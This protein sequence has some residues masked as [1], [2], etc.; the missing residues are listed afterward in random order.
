MIR[1]IL[2]VVLS[3][4]W[5]LDHTANDNWRTAYELKQS[6]DTHVPFPPGTCPCWDRSELRAWCWN[7][8]QDGDKFEP[9]RPKGRK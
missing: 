6:Q 3:L 5:L 8:A 7:H 2:A 1:V 4:L 9:I